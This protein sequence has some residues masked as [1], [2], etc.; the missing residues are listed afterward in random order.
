MQEFVNE[1][2][3]LTITKS[4]RNLLSRLMIY[5]LYLNFP[6]FVV[7]NFLEQNFADG[8]YTLYV[9]CTAEEGKLVAGVL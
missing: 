1:V 9:P 3:Y 7:E 6:L 4:T 2:P 5:L 8:I